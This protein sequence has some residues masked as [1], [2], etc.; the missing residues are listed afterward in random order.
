MK[1]NLLDYFLN[2]TGKKIHKWIHYFPIYEKHFSQ[3]IGK[4]CLMIEIGVS[5]GGS[6]QMWKDYLGPKSTIVGIDISPE[7]KKLQYN[8]PNIHIRIGNQCDTNF[9]QQVIDEFGTPNILLDDGSH[10]MSE[11][12]ITFDFLYPKMGLDS[13]YFI[14]D[15]HTCYWNEMYDG[16][17]ENP[18]TFTNRSKNFIDLINAYWTQGLISPN[19]ITD[20]TFGMHIYDS[21]ICFEKGKIS[22][23]DAPV[24]GNQ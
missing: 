20:E 2:N 5:A 23:R 11:I 22:V 12:N 24:I 21:I 10:I 9:L 3:F 8:D 17:L 18:N 14:E 6:L 15:L 19:Y 1:I 7:C 4:P 16:G 13:V